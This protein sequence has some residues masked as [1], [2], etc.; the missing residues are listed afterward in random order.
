M[1]PSRGYGTAEPEAS[2]KS[3]TGTVHRTVPENHIRRAAAVWWID[4]DDVANNKRS[5]LCN[6]DIHPSIPNWHG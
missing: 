3:P 6:S 2:S 4:S 5:M 1:T